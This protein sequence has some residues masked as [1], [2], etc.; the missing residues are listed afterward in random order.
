MGIGLA[1]GAISCFQ[2]SRELA[3]GRSQY[4]ALSPFLS[5]WPGGPGLV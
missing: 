1:D 2:N 5:L 4:S 3:M